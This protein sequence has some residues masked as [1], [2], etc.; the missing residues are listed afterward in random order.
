[1]SIAWRMAQSGISVTVFDAGRIGGRERGVA[2]WAGAGMLAPGGEVEGSSRWAELSVESL[3]LYPAFVAELREESGMSI[4]FRQCGA[5]ERDPTPGRAEAQQVL[6]IRSERLS[7]REIF[8][9]DDAMVDPRN[10]VQSLKVACERRGVVLREDEPVHRVDGPAVIAAGAWSSAIETPIPILPSFPIKGFLVSYRMEP[11]SLGPILRSGH[12]YILQRSS[13]VTIAGS[14]T[15]R[16]GFDSSLSAEIVADI[17][18]RARELLPSLPEPES[19]WFGFRPATASLEP[20]V[21]RLPGTDIYL[22]YGHYRNGILLAPIT[23][24][25]Q[26]DL[27]SNA[28]GHL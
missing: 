3:K 10:V 5:I 19:S 16:A 26:M 7:D 9:P 6:G 13:G 14:S 21:R 18:R 27:L 8:Y 28:A 15:E 23:A 12:T 22:A 17:D 25:L 2:S 1:M 4:D 24:N 20:E 11:G